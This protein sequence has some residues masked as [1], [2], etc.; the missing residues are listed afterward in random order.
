MLTGRQ[1]KAAR[2]LLNLPR[3]K[4]AE[5][6]NISNAIIRI[7][8]SVDGECPITVARALQIRSY[9]EAHG[10]EL[11]PE[12]SEPAVRLIEQYARR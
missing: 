9:L 3:S 5:R 6:M 11:L 10:I 1:L 8:E 2:A 12:N 7:A 4:L